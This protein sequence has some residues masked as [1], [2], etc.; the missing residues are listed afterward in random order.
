[1]LKSPCK[2]LI[3]GAGE[4]GR[5]YADYVAEHPDEG[6]LVGVAEPRDYQR[7]RMA[8]RHKIPT[9]RVFRD[10][11]D[12]AARERFADAVIIATQDR[13]HVEPACVFAQQGYAILLEKP[14]ATS[15]EGC[16]TIAEAM[17]RTGVMFAVCH[18]LRYTPYT[19]R[20]KRV[21]D[22]GRIGDIISVQHLEPVGYWHQAHS[23]VRGNWRN[24]T[25]SSPMLL[26]K[27]CHDLD[28]MQYIIG[29]RC[30]KVSSFG[31]LKHFR[32]ENRPEGAADRCLDCAVSCQC[33]YS[34]VRLYTKLLEQG[35][36]GWP[37]R[38]IT[39]NISTE[40][41]IEALRKGPYGRCVYACD[42]DVV[43]H[44]T[45]NMEFEN[46]TTATFT[47]TA[48]TGLGYG[49]TTRIFGSRGEIL[50]D[51]RSIRIMDFLT[52]EK[53]E[54]HLNTASTNADGGHGGGDSG[55]MR[56][57]LAA[58]AENDPEKITTGLAE[59]YDSHA[60][61][62]AAETARKESRVV[63]VPRLSLVT[64]PHN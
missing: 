4:R 5:A 7:E 12:A 36:T 14:M 47:M 8:Q 52:D 22:S 1:M 59:S 2:I 16:Q 6:I 50:G 39:N 25:E 13:M 24:E 30:K 10:W 34:A 19:Q 9:A 3:I 26:A 61:V 51:S 45:V 35:H 17:L 46:G 49:R 38:V 23:F 60:L 44:Q 15:Q 32:P 58:V 11:R 29:A 43:D 57:F 31:S 21:L 27:S 40:G 37:L 64:E 18:V 53:E 55:I 20:L 48:F 42:N 28:W 62:F 63:D 41:V 54:L 33:P 56:R